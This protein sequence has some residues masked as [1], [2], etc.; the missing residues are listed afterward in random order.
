MRLGEIGM[1][2]VRKTRVRKTNCLQCLLL[3]HLVLTQTTTASREIWKEWGENGE[4]QQGMGGVGD[5]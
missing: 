3:F 4:P 5:R 2:V 1:E